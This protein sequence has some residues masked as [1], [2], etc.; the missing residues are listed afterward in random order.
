M[1]GVL[2]R[3]LTS[4][5]ALSLAPLSL[6]AS[7]PMHLTLFSIPS[8]LPWSL[9]CFVCLLT[10]CFAFLLLPSSILHFLLF[11]PFLVILG[12]PIS[13][14]LTTS[15]HFPSSDPLGP[16]T[17]SL[18]APPP[19]VLTPPH[20]ALCAAVHTLGLQRGLVAKASLSPWGCLSW[21]VCVGRR[22]GLGVS[23]K[24]YGPLSPRGWGI[25][26]TTP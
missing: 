7:F 17:I 6:L 26:P 10:F 25:Q 15:P 9:P 24:G 1:R 18:S 23:T 4:S 19:K 22:W 5:G 21:C 14:V 16:E 2:Y 20:T 3:A 11:A 13:C 8:L 12:F